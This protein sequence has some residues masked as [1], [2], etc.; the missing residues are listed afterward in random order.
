MV[1]EA[2]GIT[3]EN[4]VL[5]LYDDVTLL[6]TYGGTYSATTGKWAFTIPE[7]KQGLYWYCIY[8]KE[9]KPCLKKPIKFE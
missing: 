9:N 2:E 4:P 6:D 3:T 7:R 5:M 1:I 8:E